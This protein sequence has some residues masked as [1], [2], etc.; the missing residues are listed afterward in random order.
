MKYSGGQITK[1]GQVLA[2]GS[3][4]AEDFEHAMDILSHWRFCHEGPLNEAFRILK[5]VVTPIDRNAI[6]A[7][8]LKRF[9][10]IYKKLSR[11]HGMT[12]RNMQDIGGCRA[13]VATEKKLWQSVRQ[14]RKRAEFKTEKGNLRVK[15]YINSPKDDGYRSYHLIGRFQDGAEAPRNIEIQIRTKTQH[16]WATALEIVDLFTAQALKSNQ[17]DAKWRDFFRELGCQFAIMDR[18]HLFESIPESRKKAKFKDHL[19]ADEALRVSLRKVTSLSK[20]LKVIEILQAYAGSIHIIDQHLGERQKKGYVLLRID[21][22]KTTVAPV[23]F[24]EDS[25]EKAKDA[26]IE[27]EKDAAQDSNMVVALVSSTALGGIK[28]AYP[29]F[30]ADSTE[31]LRRLSFLHRIEN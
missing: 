9:V 14:L 22:K 21:L 24:S 17:G 27:A 13:V 8:R 1:A 7:K 31:F 20:S 12:L 25:G 16:Y 4:A 10:S 5:Q 26:Y 11:F 18:I 23:I 2:D 29:N 3:A 28:E 19:K 15:D 6:F 30:F